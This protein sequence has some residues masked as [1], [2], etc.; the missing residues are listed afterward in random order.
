[1]SRDL[2]QRMAGANIGGGF[3]GG[4]GPSRG[5]GAGGGGQRPSGPPP[6]APGTVLTGRSNAFEIAIRPGSF[7]YRYDVEI[8]KL[9]EGVRPD[10]HLTKQNDPGLRT[11]QKECCADIVEALHG[12]TGGFGANAHFVYDGKNTLYTTADIRPIIAQTIEPEQLKRRAAMFVRNSRIAVSVKPNEA[13]PR[14]DLSA[15]D[16]ALV[17]DVAEQADRTARNFLELATTQYVCNIDEYQRV[18]AGTIFETREADLVDGM[19]MRVGV[20]KGIV[21]V[22]KLNEGAIRRLL[23]QS[24][25]DQVSPKLL[26]EA[27]EAATA[28]ACKN[29]RRPTRVL[30]LRDG[31]SEGRQENVVKNELP[32]IRNGVTRTDVPEFYAQAHHPLK[33]SPKVPQYAVLV[34]ELG[35]EPRRL[36]QAMLLLSNAHQV[37]AC[38]TSLPVPVYLA[39]ETAKRGM[40]IY[41]A[42]LI[43][44]QSGLMNEVV[45]NDMGMFDPRKLNELL[46]YVGSPLYGTRFNA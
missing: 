18:C 11:A 35:I 19:N 36:E 40:E 42:F 24:R 45:R 37:C 15:L 39:D 4:P 38:P 9:G 25:S 29:G 17:G 27:V 46:G 21:P 22:E 3:R 6:V 8:V 28:A 5:G 43:H 12:L 2:S 23:L 31:V 26:R 10:R 44:R 41:Q 14:I 34:N 16:P 30:V 1:M 32:Q 20:K 13:A 33:G 7:A